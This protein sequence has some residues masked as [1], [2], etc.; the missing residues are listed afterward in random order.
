VTLSPPGFTAADTEADG[1]AVGTACHR[2]LE[3][4]DLAQLSDAVAVQSQVARLVEAG[5]LSAAE[6]ALLPIAD[7]AWF[8]NTTDGLALAA[9]PGVRREVPFVYALPLDAGGERTIVRGVIDCL[10]ESPSGLVL[11]DYK[12]D[13]PRDDADWAA[14]LA[15]YH[16]QLQVYAHAA[17][18]IFGRPVTRA[19]LV[20]L[21][22]RRSE[23][24]RIEALRTAVLLRAD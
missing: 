21:R 12:T 23:D 10:Y 22:A 15:G 4:A 9:G 19:V 13:L 11:L 14:R 7:L 5:R 8:G 16:V 3:H 6:A 24:V 1:R 18:A 20:F 17:A 2:F